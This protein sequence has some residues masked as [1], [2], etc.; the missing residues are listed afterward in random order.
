LGASPCH[1]HSC[2]S[3]LR[4][5]K[6][7]PRQLQT[8]NDLLQLLTEHPALYAVDFGQSRGKWAAAAPL[9]LAAAAAALADTGDAHRVCVRLRP[10]AWRQRLL[11]HQELAGLVE[12]RAGA[13][14]EPVQEGK[15][16]PELL[17]HV[18]GGMAAA[19]RQRDRLHAAVLLFVGHHHLC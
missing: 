13:A 18:Q 11:Q 17:S 14:V 4:L 2:W 15:L 6:A 1:C 3:E 9:A 10:E 16:V 5:D 19:G 8:E 7:L 12:E